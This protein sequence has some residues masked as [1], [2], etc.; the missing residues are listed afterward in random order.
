MSTED[1]TAQRRETFG[2][3]GNPC[4]T[5]WT[6][7]DEAWARHLAHCT[8]CQR[9][10]RTRSRG[11][12]QSREGRPGDRRPIDLTSYAEP[13]RAARGAQQAPQQGPKGRP[14]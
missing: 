10:E 8:R 5:A 11:G 4:F 2:D 3:W 9:D 1:W 6:G 14:G 13:H 12:Q 7:G